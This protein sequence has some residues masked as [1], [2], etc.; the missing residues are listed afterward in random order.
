M[1]GCCSSRLNT[2]K[3]VNW[4]VELK[5]Y[6]KAAQKDMKLKRSSRDRTEQESSSN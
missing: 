4:K 5:L 6:E 2:I 1:D 3:K